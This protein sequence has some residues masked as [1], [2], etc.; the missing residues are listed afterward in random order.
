MARHELTDMQRKVVK[1]HVP[2]PKR[3][4]R[5][6]RDR[7]QVLDGILWILRTGAPWRDLPDRYCPWKTVYHYINKWRE[8]G[9]FDR[10]MDA[11]QVRLDRQGEIDWD[12]W[13]IDGSSIRATRAAAGGGE[14]GGQKNQRTTPSGGHEAD[15]E[16]SST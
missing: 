8:N 12:L 6:P 1:E 16:P 5:P 15:S 4:G 3:Q 7:R 10:I 11:L 9:T 2:E 13:C 14:K